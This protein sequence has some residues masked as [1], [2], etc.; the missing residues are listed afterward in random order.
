[1]NKERLIIKNDL[2]RVCVYHKRLLETMQTLHLDP[3]FVL[4]S[5]KIPDANKYGNQIKMFSLDI[6]FGV[7]HNISKRAEINPREFG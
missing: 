3:F 2:K 6:F 1:M 7:F 5:S 4:F